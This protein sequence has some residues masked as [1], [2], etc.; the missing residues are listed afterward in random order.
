MNEELKKWREQYWK[1]SGGPREVG[2]FF[3]AMF[4][5]ITLGITLYFLFDDINIFTGFVIVIFIFPFL[6]FWWKPAWTLYRKI[7]GNPNLPAEPMPRVKV[8]NEFRELNLKWWHWL[9]IGW[10]I[11]M[12]LALFYV[13]FKYL[14]K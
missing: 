12:N 6:I 3:I 4:T 10:G 2:R 9:I 14:S 7:L 13:A 5:W 8:V 1:N 11:L